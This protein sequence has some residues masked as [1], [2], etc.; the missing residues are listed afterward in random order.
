ML[1][2]LVKIRILDDGVRCLDG[3]LL[4]LHKQSSRGDR[5]IDDGA[6]SH[7]QTLT[8]TMSRGVRRALKIRWAQ[9]DGLINYLFQRV[10]PVTLI[11]PLLARLGSKG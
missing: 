2:T 5:L 11:L 7:H 4:V 1:R 9:F 3:M 8:Y 10:V 6:V